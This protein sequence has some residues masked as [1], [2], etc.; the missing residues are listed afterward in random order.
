MLFMLEQY[1]WAD[2]Y[3]AYIFMLYPD[4]NMQTW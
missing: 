2:V 3:D 4:A 1:D